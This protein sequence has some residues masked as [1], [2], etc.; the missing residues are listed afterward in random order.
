MNE[1]IFKPCDVDEVGQIIEK[2]GFL[3]KDEVAANRLE[4][5]IQAAPVDYSEINLDDYERNLYM[6]TEILS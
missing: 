1:V 4:E 6:E 5:L 2:I 3:K